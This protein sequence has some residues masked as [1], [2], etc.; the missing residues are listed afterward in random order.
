MT[1]R[2]ML[3]LAL[4]ACVTVAAVSDLAWRKIPN[5]VVLAGLLAALPLHLLDGGLRGLP[6]SWL[7]GA[8]TGFFLFLP[9]Y[10]MR[11]MAAGDVKLMA[12]VGAFSGPWPA[13]L[14]CFATF[15][16]GGLMAIAIVLYQGRWRACLR[17]LRL[18]L[19]PLLMRT[20]G[21]P[22]APTSLAPGSSV[23]GMPYGLA[24]ALGTLLWLGWRYRE[25]FF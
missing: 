11:G 7:G 21:L 14:I 12:M 17:N 1:A 2:L 5:R 25:L 3:D 6:A 10:A 24:I 4:L 13:L 16:I 19:W 20:A 8:L 15:V 9:M 23:G 22:L 18:L